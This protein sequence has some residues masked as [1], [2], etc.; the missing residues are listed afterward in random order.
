MHEARQY[1][2]GRAPREP[3]AALPS[4][5]LRCNG[6]LSIL[7]SSVR[8]LHDRGRHGR[9]QGGRVGQRWQKIER[10]LDL[11]VV[12]AAVG[13]LA[14]DVRALEVAQ[15]AQ[16]HGHARAAI[17]RVPN[18]ADIE[19]RELQRLQVLKQ[20]A[21]H[22]VTPHR[23]HQVRLHPKAGQRHCLVRARAARSSGERA[24]RITRHPS[25]L[26]SPLRLGS[27]IHVQRAEHHA[28]EDGT[29]IG[30]IGKPDVTRASRAC[31]R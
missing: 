18:T 9:R 29:A 13:A 1:S 21:A 25:I 27:Q 23:T 12:D 22:L 24:N 5:R 2:H 3:P 8:P 10:R 4:G 6:W 17:F 19:R 31:I 28:T 26:P 7:R 20:Q 16:L 11:N 30:A 15:R 14:H